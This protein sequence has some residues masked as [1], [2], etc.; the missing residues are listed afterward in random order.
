MPFKSEQ[1]RK[2]FYAAAAGKVKSISP[3]VAKKFIKDSG[4]QTDLPRYARKHG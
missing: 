2:L 4:R 1:Q 3:R